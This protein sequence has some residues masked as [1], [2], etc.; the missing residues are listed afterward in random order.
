MSSE[1]L[2][3]FLAKV[4]LDKSTQDRLKEAKTP[5]QV[6]EIAKEHGHHFAEDV[7]ESRQ[8]T[9]AELEGIEGGN[10]VTASWFNV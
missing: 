7:L 5:D 8:L 1:Q 9:D 4:R 6:L 10:C 3:A 2:N